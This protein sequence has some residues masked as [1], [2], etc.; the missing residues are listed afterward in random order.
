MK[1]LRSIFLL[2]FAFVLWGFISCNKHYKAQQTRYIDYRVSAQDSSETSTVFNKTIEPY[3]N[4]LEQEM[5]EI[6]G[7]ASFEMVKASPEGGLGNWIADMT[8]VQGQKYYNKPVDFGLCNQGGIRLPSFPKGAITVGKIFELLP[9]DNF[10]TIVLLDK[11]QVIQ[12]F[13]YM[14]QKGGWPVSKGVK[15][16]I[17]NNKATEITIN[18]KPLED[19]TYAVAMND[20]VASGGDGCDFIA[21]APKWES[22]VLIRDAM[23]DFTKT[24]TSKNEQI[25]FKSEGR[26]TIV[27]H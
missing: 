5:N 9:F 3:R 7:V 22:S 24:Y 2:S 13:D 23:I 8:Q 18:G 14:A 19:K 25:A 27:L 17:V 12:L 16:F 11:N 6:I 1:S 15:Y 21:N 4:K 20:Y 26:V 10:L